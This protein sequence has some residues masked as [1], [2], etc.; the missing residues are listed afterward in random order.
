MSREL[1]RA[2]SATLP[3]GRRPQKVLRIA[4][5]FTLRR[6]PRTQKWL[7]A[8]SVFT[9]NPLCGRRLSTLNRLHNPI[10]NRYLDIL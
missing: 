2:E 1:R 4:E 3:A 5:L 8:R 6:P 7:Q 9:Q 10:D